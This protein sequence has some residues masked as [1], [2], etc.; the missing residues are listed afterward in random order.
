M[1]NAKKSFDIGYTVIMFIIVILLGL[2]MI[3]QY[4]SKT[5]TNPTFFIVY[6]SLGGFGFLGMIMV[7]FFQIFD[8]KH[9]SEEEE[10]VASAAFISDSSPTRMLSHPI[11]RL[12]VVLFLVVFVLVIVSAAGK[13]IIPV[14][15]PYG[16]EPISKSILESHPFLLNAFNIGFYPGLYEELPIFI[17]INF[18]ILALSW[19]LSALLTRL[20][21]Q[22]KRNNVVLLL[23]CSIIAISIG[24]GV[25]T[26]AHGRAYDMNTQAYISAYAFEWIVQAANQATGLFISWIPHIIHNISYVAVQ[27][28]SLSIGMATLMIAAPKNWLLILRSLIKS[29]YDR[30]KS[31]S[32]CFS[33]KKNMSY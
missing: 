26:F 8:K 11:A 1:V 31:D 30:F 2:F 21:L 24:A 14:Y 22:V 13:N 20:G 7:V 16:S 9:E 27:T 32:R 29:S 12:L 10:A 5:I 18:I 33:W 25:F 6:V 15:N 28:I 23:F 3:F 17:M 19:P 4:G